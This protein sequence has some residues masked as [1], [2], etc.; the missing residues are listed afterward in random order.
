LKGQVSRRDLE[1]NHTNTSNLRGIKKVHSDKTLQNFTT[2]IRPMNA[3]TFSKSWIGGW[4]FLWLAVTLPSAETMAGSLSKIL[5]LGDSYVDDGNY[6]ALNKGA[7]PDYFSNASPWSTVANLALGLPSAAR[8]AGDHSPSGN[9]YAVA[10]AGINISPTAADTSLHGQVTKLLKDYPHGLPADSLVVIAIGTNDVRA[11]V[12]FGGIWSNAS[13][14]WK[15]GKTGFTVPAADSSVTVPVTSTAGMTAG[16]MNLVAFTNGGAPVMMA[17]T[18]I[19][20]AG[21]TVTF[22][23]KF[24]SPGTN[25]AANSTFEVCAKWFLDQVLPIFAA[26]LK[27]VVADQGHVVLVLLPPT[28]MLPTYN[29]QSNQA[30][31]HETWRYVYEKMRA[32]STTD[33]EKIVVFDLKSVFQDVFSDPTHYG[34]K[35]N[36]P[37]WQGTGAADPNEYMFYDGF[38]PSGSMHKLIAQ[39]FVEFLRAKGLAERL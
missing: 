11:V 27:S 18:K 8:W 5:Y 34:F 20:P 22:T 39:R 29:H 3:L 9:N 31:A 25:V 16:P 21:N 12:G 35:V 32:L 30:L 28:D 4:L 6:K 15:L 7:G 19:D 10:G 14:E 26:D 33:A 2:K 38:H 36:Y 13:T 23:N 24:G 17:L 37:C 1:Q